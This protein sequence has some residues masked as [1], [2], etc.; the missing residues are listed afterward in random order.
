M[1]YANRDAEYRIL[2]QLIESGVNPIFIYAY[3]ASGVTSF[4]KRRMKDVCASLFGT[5]ILYIDAANGA[6]L[7]ELLLRQLVCSDYFE[8]LQKFADKKWG[9]HA[10]SL[11]SSALECI[12]Y[13]GPFL[14]RLS[15]QRAAIPLYSGV[16]PSAMEEIL[17]CFFEENTSPFLVVIDTVEQLGEDSYELLLGLLRARYVRCLLVRTENTLNYDKLENFLFEEGIG[18]SSYLDFDRPQVKLVKELGALYDIPISSDEATEIVAK[19][20]HNIH[21]II[22]EIRNIKLHSQESSLTQWE[23]AVISILNIWQSPMPEETLYQILSRSE[24][25]SCNS[26]ETFRD[27]LHTLKTKDLIET[28]SIGLSIKG[29]YNPQIQN[30]LNRI[31]DQLYY[32]NVIYEFLADSDCAIKNNSLRYRLSKEL[33]CT[34]SNDAKAYLR[35]SIISGKDVP[36][37]L[38][39]ESHLKRGNVDDCLLAGIKYCRERK[40]EQSYEWIS[41]IPTRARTPD[42]DALMASLLNRLRRSEEAEIA[43]KKCLAHDMNPSHQNLLSAFLISTYVHMERLKDAQIVYKEKVGL[44]PSNPMHGYLV[45]NATS[46][47]R[48]YREDLYQLALQDFLRDKDDFGYYTTMCNQGYA[49]CRNGN[50]RGALLLLQK[51]LD[52]LE[53]FPRSNLHIVYNDLGICNFYLGEYQ[54]AYHYFLLAHRFARNSMPEIFSTINIA[55]LEAVTGKTKQAASRMESIYSKVE[56]HKLNRVRQ[57]YYINYLLVEYLNG[58]KDIE[59]W[60][61]KA[62]LYP[63]RYSPTF[64]T[65][66]AYFYRQYM[67]TTQK[68]ICRDWR[69]LYSPCGLAYWYM[70]P[71]KFLSEGFIN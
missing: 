55:C 56:Q 47:F 28:D 33:N 63:D 54:N 70:D 38:L 40:F 60:I 26:L 20:Q 45:R 36:R 43:L 16:Y 62:Q 58:N 2:R 51:A 10:Q 48:E 65:H 59:K 12:P 42:I 8:Q 5:N 9:E 21:S 27:T 31:S 67:D 18:M 32:K 13:A 1:N 64:T 68:A 30:I 57:K 15:E 50:Y 39:D 61:L 19:T 6:S 22:K 49:L 44:F 52:G 37:E 14:S 23:K 35:Q 71:L 25:F 17:T 7:S 34:T 4:V 3:H 46:A 11:L 29:Q 24:V 69:D 53:C 66:V 41:T